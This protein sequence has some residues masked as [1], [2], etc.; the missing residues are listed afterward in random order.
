M[1][2]EMTERNR[3]VVEDRES[4][5]TYREIAERYGFSIERGRQ[6]VVGVERRNRLLLYRVRQQ[7]DHNRWDRLNPIT[8][9]LPKRIQNGLL[10]VGI[11][12]DTS[13]LMASDMQLR[14]IR[15]FGE[16]T[17]AEINEKRRG[18]G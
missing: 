18:T 16:K 8:K 3:R 1:M 10:L 11:R 6:I 14:S 9:S 7:Q 4:G 2:D 5:M 12:D 13:L 17:V 15:N